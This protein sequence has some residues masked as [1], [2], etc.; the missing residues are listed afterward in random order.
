[1]LKLLYFKKL[2]CITRSQLYW[3]GLL[4]ALATRLAWPANAFSQVRPLKLQKGNSRIT[5]IDSLRVVQYI[6]SSR[7][8]HRHRHQEKE[9]YQ[10]A[11]RAVDVSLVLNDTLLY[12]RSLDNLGLL[13]RYHEWYEQAIPLHVK[14]FELAISPEIGPLYKMIFANNVGVAARYAQ[15]YDLAVEYYLK[16]LKIAVEHNNLKN[17]AISSN[18]LG[19]ALGSISGKEEIA[20]TY[21]MRGLQ[22]ERQLNDSLGVAMNLLSISDYYINN[23]NYP[24][25]RSY[26]DTLYVINQA[27]SDLFGLAITNEFYGHTYFKENRQLEKAKNYYVLSLQQFRKL[28]SATKEAELMGSLGELQHRRGNLNTALN[29]YTK[30]LKLAD[31]IHN[32]ALIVENAY[33]IY[34]IKKQQNKYPEALYYYQKAKSYEDSIA[35]SHQRIK[36]AALTSQYNLEKKESRIELLQEENLLGAEQIAMQKEILF[37]HKIYFIILIAGLILIVLFIVLQNK[38]RRIK[39]Q[40]EKLLQQKQEELTIAK[41]EKSIAQAE[42]LAARTQLNPH[43]LFNSLNA[44][45]LL[46]QKFQTKKAEQYLIK[47]SRFIRMILELPKSQTISLNEELTLIRYYIALE[48]KRFDDDFSFQLNNASENEMEN[49][50]IPPLLLQPFVENAI[51]HGLLPSGKRCKQLSIHIDRENDDVHICI[52]DN[53]VGRES[54]E[55]VGRYNG[56]KDKKSMGMKI[57]RERIEQFNKSYNCKINLSVVDKRNTKGEGSGTQI[58]LTLR[59]CIDTIIKSNQE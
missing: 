3:V 23:G 53:G 13:Y 43:F 25:A 6:D 47:L 18:G 26:L 42:M 54:Q 7:A 10:Y 46:I 12:A 1:M 28:N 16:G 9:E 27:K 51:W 55:I 41:Y 48:E 11:N 39:K 5:E 35:L 57:T 20:L 33:H 58:L 24:K 2:I 50:R 34:K 19:N 17:I 38:N 45:H 49:I 32:K 56:Q 36:I 31:S 8:I 29:L 14:A 52:E 4:F 59:D 15:R 40:A 22:V 30:S 37:T 44:I 21:F